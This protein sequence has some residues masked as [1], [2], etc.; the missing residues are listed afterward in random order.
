MALVRLNG[1]GMVWP[2][3]MAIASQWAGF[4]T[5]AVDAANKYYYALGDVW[6]PDRTALTK[7]ITHVHFR[8]F[9]TP[10]INAASQ[11]RVSLQDVNLANSTVPARPDL[12]VDQQ[13][14][15]AAGV[16]PTSDWNRV[17]L[18]TSRTVTRGDSQLAVV[19]DWAAFTAASSVTMFVQ[20]QSTNS[21]MSG[22]ALAR[23]YNGSSFSGASGF[24]A[25]V[26]EFSDGTYGSFDGTRVG[27]PG[28]LGLSTSTPEYAL[29]F[30]PQ[31]TMLVDGV[32]LAAQV[33]NLSANFAVALYENTTALKTLVIDA[34]SLSDSNSDSRY[35][36]LF[37]QE[38]QLTAGTTYYV[39]VRGLTATSLDLGAI[40]APTAVT[41]FAS[42]IGPNA[43]RVQRSNGSSGSWG[44]VSTTSYP[45]IGLLVSGLDDGA[46]VSLSGSHT[47]SGT[48]TV[49]GT[50]VSGATVRLI[51]QSD[52]AVASTITNAQGQYSFSVAG[53]YLYHAIA[54]WTNSGQKYN[55]KSLWDLTPVAP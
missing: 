6:W 55:A 49:S 11:F 51:R 45:M 50:P 4:S 37:D 13:Y 25:M 14:T 43:A 7:T 22:R 16:G 31:A 27:V 46:G 54:E 18:T 19:F 2:D 23:L 8:V 20:Q 41:S 35:R 53:G 17:A 28:T 12:V 1:G 44:T 33:S 30:T 24:P 3:I 5:A 36:F 21:G 40:E 10:T 39:G 9:G 52:N 26:F 38:V 29:R 34:S 42:W 32:M 48:V 15:Y 47:I